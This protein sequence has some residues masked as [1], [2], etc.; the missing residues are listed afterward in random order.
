MQP[1]ALRSEAE[2]VYN[3]S[4]ESA[5]GF[6]LCNNFPALPQGRVYQVWFVFQGAAEPVATFLPTGDGACQIPMDLSRVTSRPAGIGISIE[7]ES[8]SM[9]PSGGWFAYASFE[10]RSRSGGN[11]IDFTVSAFGP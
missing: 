3:W 10:P 6:I 9:R 8:G 4:R 2:S 5:A 1:V 11:G 7:P